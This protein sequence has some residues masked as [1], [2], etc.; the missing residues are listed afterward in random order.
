MKYCVCTSSNV[1]RDKR[2]KEPCPFCGT[3]A[4]DIQIRSF[5]DGVN[6]IYCPN[7]KATFDGFDSKQ[8]LINKWNT[9]YR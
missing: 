4:E 9:R 6:K 3:N 2:I 8:A 5:R 7:C 1:L